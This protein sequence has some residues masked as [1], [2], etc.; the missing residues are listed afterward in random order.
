[1]T[2]LEFD[3]YNT[4]EMLNNGLDANK[5]VYLFSNEQLERY[6][7][8]TDF[9]NKKV[10]SIT[11]SG[12]PDKVFHYDEL[13]ENYDD[14]FEFYTN[15]DLVKLIDVFE[16]FKVENFEENTINK[17]LYF[18]ALR[19]WIEKQFYMD[20]PNDKTLKNK[21]TIGDKIDYMFSG[22]WG[23][24]DKV[25]REYLMSKKVML[26]H[27]LHPESQREPFYY[28]LNMTFKNIKDEILD[29]KNHFMK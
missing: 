14:A 11:G 12:D 18:T 23:G 15:E 21:K 7:N 4:F 10:L 8:Y 28:I 22:N 20:R 5:R 24:S 2:N 6:I 3:L 9:D 17:I 16:D 26:N 19:V 27:H 29:I 1:M 13:C 25:T